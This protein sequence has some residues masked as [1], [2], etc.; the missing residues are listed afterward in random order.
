[1]LLCHQCPIVT[2]V[3]ASEQA[4]HTPVASFLL[5]QRGISAL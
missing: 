2:A 5:S 4:L 3:A 1:M